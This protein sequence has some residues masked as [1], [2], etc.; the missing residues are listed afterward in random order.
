[1]TFVPTLQGEF[2]NWDDYILFTKNLEF[3]GLGWPHLRWMFTNTLA[4]HYIPLTWLTLGLNYS[5]GGMNP[6]GFHFAAIMLHATN[7]TLFY[8]VARRLLAAALDPDGTQR[9]ADELPVE[10]SGGAMLA[11]LVFAIHPQRVES[12]AWITDRGTL[13]ERS[14]IPRLRSAICV[15]SPRLAPSGGAG[16]VFSRS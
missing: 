16:G 2:L 9:A 6:W 7:A 1:M 12:V 10:V 3:R 15:P 5:L 8:L 11:A 13:P 4:G 14:A